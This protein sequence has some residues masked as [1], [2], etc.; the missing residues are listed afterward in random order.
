[1][2]QLNCEHVLDVYPD[3]LNGKADGAA[4]ES[5]RAHIA[6]CEECRAAAALLEAVYADRVSAPAELRERVVRGLAQPR[7][8]R[9]F[10]RSDM[11]MAATL[12]AA[13]IGGSVILQ[14]RQNQTQQPAAAVQSQAQLGVGF[15][16]VEDAMLSGDASLD[17]LSVEQLEKLLGEIES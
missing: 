13:L 15:V 11:A 1:M 9:R 2:S 12:A 4:A 16:S 8:R 5:V 7:A 10:T 14:S 6:G 17:D 3:V